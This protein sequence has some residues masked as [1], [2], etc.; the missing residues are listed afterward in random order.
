MKRETLWLLGIILLGTGLRLWLAT[1]S[2]NFDIVAIT[3][4]VK[5]FDEGKNVYVYQT[6]YNYSP[7]L[8]WIFG[9]LG[10]IQKTLRVFSLP[11]VI[12][13]FTSVIDLLTLVPLMGLASR[14]GLSRIKVA[15]LFFLNPVTITISGH[16]GQY[17]NIPMLGL[18]L[19]L[20]IYTSTSFPTKY[21]LFTAWLVVTL[22]FIMKHITLVQVMVF[23]KLQFPKGRWLLPYISALI[24]FFMTFIPY[25]DVFGDI[26]RQV[27]GYGGLQG[28]YGISY[29]TQIFCATCTV[30]GWP[31]NSILRFL[32]LPLYFL[33]AW[34]I[35]HKSVARGLL[36]SILF[37]MV[38]T[39]G[40][41][42][43]YFVLPIALG[44]LF[45]SKWFYLYS[46]VT[47]LFYLGSIDEYAI[48]AFGT[49]TWNTV[50]LFAL[51]WFASEWWQAKKTT[52][53]T[54]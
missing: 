26:K 40:I 51:C 49:F 5:L 6:A 43:Q 48:P 20:W 12:R 19:G 23:W 15:A 32:F 13:A 47:F 11:F 39:S 37:F 17:D 8:F 2:Y 33:F 22:G 53:P 16:H 45:P 31:L 7:L 24:L 27:F 3:Q 25:L 21:K 1:G 4:D 10:I 30:F 9:L 28:F 44:T 41:A 50:W 42:A 18:L 52:A 38:F 29:F 35:R 46:G 34:Q 54:H 36:L 14:F